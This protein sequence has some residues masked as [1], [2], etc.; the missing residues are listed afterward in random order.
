MYGWLAV[1]SNELTQQIHA[2]VAPVATSAA[3]P[4]HN[5]AIY[6]PASADRVHFKK[7][8]VVKKTVCKK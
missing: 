5:S 6:T 3:F 8:E 2:Y 4:P 1:L 7:K